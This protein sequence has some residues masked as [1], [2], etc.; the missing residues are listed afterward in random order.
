MGNDNKVRVSKMS[1]KISDEEKS[2]QIHKEVMLF[3]GDELERIHH[4][5]SDQSYDI[6]KE[7]AKSK[8]NHSPFSALML[9]GC[10]LLVFGISN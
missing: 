1:S 6:E 5:T 9:T 2:E 10:F 8:K 3:L 7:Y 4:G